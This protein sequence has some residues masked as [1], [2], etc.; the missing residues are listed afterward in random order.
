MHDPQI[1]FRGAVVERVP[2]SDNILHLLD[3]IAR[4]N[5]SVQRIRDF[6]AVINSRN[7]GWVDASCVIMETGDECSVRAVLEILNIELLRRDFRTSVSAEQKERLIGICR[8]VVDG[9]SRILAIKTRAFLGDSQL[10]SDAG[11][12]TE[13]LAIEV[14]GILGTTECVALLKKL[15]LN[16]E[17][18]SE[19]EAC[20]RY[21]ARNSDADGEGFLVE[22][23]SRGPGRRSHVENACA[24]AN[25]SNAVGAA[26]ILGLLEC[27]CVAPI[28]S[29]ID[30]YVI[31]M[32]FERK[33]HLY[34]TKVEF[35]SDW[36]GTAIEFLRSVVRGCKSASVL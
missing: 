33:C 34:M 11:V 2:S 1:A 8:R 15:F 9:E 21:L 4:S 5:D 19:K 10:L 30:D 3:T 16:L 32:L 28:V 29:G 14:Y 18:E 22:Q 13:W 25:I 6:V 20:A 26:Y 23:I 17:S 35:G 36:R 27:M 24:L 12:N 31:N 7:T